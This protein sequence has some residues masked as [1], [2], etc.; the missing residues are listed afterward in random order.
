M[1]EADVCICT[2]PLPVLAKVAWESRRF[3]EQD[4]FQFGGLG[5]TDEANE[6]VWYPRGGIGEKTGVLVGAY[7]IGFSGP[8][9]PP[10]YA[11]MSFD[12]RFALSRRVIDKFHPGHGKELTKPV[13]VSWMQTPYS[14]GVAVGWKDEQRTTDYA[15]LCKPDGA[16]Y[17]AGKHM[18]YINAWQE[19]AGPVGS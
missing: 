7:S 19:G 11:A 16:F 9:A 5:W 14:E 2:I 10:K 15:E 3:W 17:F 18:S 12:E 4:D 1:L 6:L 8:D 13:S